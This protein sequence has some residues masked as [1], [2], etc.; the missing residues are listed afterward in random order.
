ML[1]DRG[2][3]QCLLPQ[4]IEF[5]SDQIVTIAYIVAEHFL[6]FY[7]SSVPPPFITNSLYHVVCQP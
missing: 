6:K 2:S 5:G 1:T 3:T 7:L 4:A